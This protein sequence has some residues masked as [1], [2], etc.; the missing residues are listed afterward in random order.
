MGD[1]QVRL[2][3]E[4]C[5]VAFAI[6]KRD[7]ATGGEAQPGATL[8]GARYKLVDA[9]GASHVATSDD[10][11]IIRFDGIPLGD[12]TLV[13]IEPPKGYR[14]DPEPHQFHVS[15]SG[16]H[17]DVLLEPSV[18][19]D[20][21]AF[22]IEIAKFKDYGDFE[23][24]V[25]QPAAGVVFEIVS[26]TTQEVVGT[27]ETNQYGF[28][29]TASNPDAWFGEGSRPDGA[30][31]AIPYDEAGYTVR[32]V[33]ENRPGRIPPRGRLDGNRRRHAGRSA[34]AVH[35]QHAI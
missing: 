22:D 17:E 8:S 25:A 14:P 6:R 2:E 20:V 21:I 32:E 18:D 27:V 16:Q 33:E 1:G 9:N 24:G 26:N 4:P 30:S 23:S 35:R 12:A 3:D 19:E 13:E 15:G 31:G 10:E 7:S 5:T 11:G 29:N 34:P 28:A